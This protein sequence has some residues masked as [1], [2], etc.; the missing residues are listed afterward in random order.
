[1]KILNI[2]RSLSGTEWGSNRQTLLHIYNAMILSRIRYGCVA[3]TSANKTNLSI[4]RPIHNLGIRI[5]TG[6]YRTSPAESVICASGFLPLHYLMT[7]DLVSILFKVISMPNHPL[8]SYLTLE[9]R[10][11]Y[12][13]KQSRSKPGILRALEKSIELNINF[14]KDNHN[15]SVAKSLEPPWLVP[16][17]LVHLNIVKHKKTSLNQF[18]IKSMFN[19]FLINY[20]NYTQIYTDGS[21]TEDQVGVGIFSEMYSQSYRLPDQ[22]TIF[23]AELTGILLALQNIISMNINKA[24]IFTDSKSSLQ[25]IKKLYP[26]HPV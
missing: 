8:N 22:Y 9:Y 2:L 7:Q 6:A 20:S 16:S 4:L 12:L 24:I 14:N 25:S 11:K 5:A 3:Y 17:I 15:I 1:M 21:Y 19:Q 23:D 13:N 10:R 18:E 26:K